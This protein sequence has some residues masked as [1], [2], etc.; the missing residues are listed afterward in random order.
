MAFERTEL[1]THKGKKVH[2]FLYSGLRGDEFIRIIKHNRGE[3]CKIAD[4]GVRSLRYVVDIRDCSFDT[5]TVNEFKESARIL[6]PYTIRV[7]VVGASGVR[8]LLLSAVNAFSN[9]GG[10]PFPS[11]EKAL[12]WVVGE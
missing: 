3:L 10:K 5:A 4:E 12:D 6:Q 7:G 8:G 2:I 11:L 1:V 9:I